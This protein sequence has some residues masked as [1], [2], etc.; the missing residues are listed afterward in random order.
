MLR[1]LGAEAFDPERA[2]RAMVRNN[3]ALGSYGLDHVLGTLWTRPQLS[4]RDRSLIV[5]TFLTTLNTAGGEEFEFHVRSALNHGLSREE[6]EEIVLQV[7]TYAGFPIAMHASRV[8]NDIWRQLDG[9]D[10]P[11]IR[12]EA[13]L[14]DDDQRH[15]NAQRVRARMWNGRNS[16]DPQADRQAMVDV[17]GGVG[18]MAFDYAFGEV[19]A[20]DAFSPR[21]RSMVT[22]AILGITHCLEELQ[23]HTRIALNH[24]CT[25]DEV[26]EIFVHMTGYSGFPRAVSA[27]NTVRS[28][29]ARID[30]KKAKQQ[31]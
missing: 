4:R 8:V 5:V 17:M 27:A 31:D 28:I 25:R 3:G 1:T 21:D 11:N 14:L 19:W 18:E 15:T 7:A 6:V 30:A 9:L 22:L 20:R 26:E 23:I 12:A 13:E 29:F 10:R 16:D 2:A 24:G